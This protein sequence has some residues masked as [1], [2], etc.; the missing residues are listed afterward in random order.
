MPAYVTA[1]VSVKDP[2]KLQA[3]LTALPATLAPF[4][5][6]P[7]CRGKVSKALHGE[8][9]YQILA[10]FSFADT[11]TAEAWYQSDAYQALI[12]NRDEALGGE[13]LVL[14]GP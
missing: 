12:P 6:K 10:V 1:T 2:S 11:A 5:G 8:A 14:E 7:V 4:G 3:Y 9:K 13:I